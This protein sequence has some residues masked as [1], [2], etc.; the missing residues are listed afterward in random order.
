MSRG[1]RC[2][3]TT[4][5]SQETPN[6]ASASAAARI[7]GQSESLPITIPARGWPLTRSPSCDT[8]ARQAPLTSSFA[9]LVAP[10]E[11]VHRAARPVP[12]VPRV[13]AEHGD[14]ADLPPGTHVLA[15]DVQLHARVGGHHMGV[16]GV[17]V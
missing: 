5:A 13:V 2:A 14:M 10:A 9:L 1:I 12:Q 16:P 3:E 15:V 4:S 11:V 7:T 8:A 17:Q 6:S